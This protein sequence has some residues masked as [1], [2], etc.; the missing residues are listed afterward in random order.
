MITLR[1]RVNVLSNLVW[2]VLLQSLYGSVREEYF[3]WL[4][5]VQAI[6]LYAPFFRIT[7]C[8]QETF[9]RDYP[10]YYLSC[11]YRVYLTLSERCE[12]EHGITV[13][14]SWPDYVLSLIALYAIVGRV[15]DRSMSRE[16]VTILMAFAGICRK[17]I[18]WTINCKSTCWSYDQALNVSY[19]LETN[20][21]DSANKGTIR[22]HSAGC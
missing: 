18:S 3:L 2:A 13:L 15:S 22:A 20:V 9:A 17:Y 12:A 4:S 16:Y 1:A 7:L 11:L 8:V 21:D 5:Y 10:A 19:Q 6:A 14:S